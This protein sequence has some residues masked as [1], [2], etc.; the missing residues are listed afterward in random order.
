MSVYMAVL[1]LKYREWE[2]ILIRFFPG[3]WIWLSSAV[4]GD[5]AITSAMFYYLHVMAKGTKS[6]ENIFQKI[7]YRS[8]QANASQ[9]RSFAKFTLQLLSNLFSVRLDQ[10]FDFFIVFIL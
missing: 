7:L 6:C 4:A 1:V 9:R 8:I 3:A 10:N 2:E 5:F